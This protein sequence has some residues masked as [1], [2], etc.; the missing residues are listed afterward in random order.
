[1]PLDE[2]VGGVEL[3]DR[4]GRDIHRKRSYGVRHNSSYADWKDYTFRA[5]RFVQRLRRLS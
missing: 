1:M 4:K 3:L 5:C 2:Q